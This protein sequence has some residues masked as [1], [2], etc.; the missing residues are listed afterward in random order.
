VGIIGGG[1]GGFNIDDLNVRVFEKIST[2]GTAILDEQ[3]SVINFQNAASAYTWTIPPESSVDF[4]VGSWMALR[5]TGA[6]DITLARGS[7]VVFQ[8]E[9]F[10]DNN[11]KLDGRE[12]Y[13][14]YIEKTAA[15][16]WLLSGA[17]K[18]V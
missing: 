14:L 16:T 1:G 3:N 7:G 13:S 6:G 9:N 8:H 18:T 12:G 2:G 15:D 5:K 4:P 11:V 17:M 10:G